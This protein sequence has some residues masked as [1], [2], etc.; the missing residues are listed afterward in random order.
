MYVQPR[1]IIIDIT[2]VSLIY[3]FVCTINCVVNILF[4]AVALDFVVVYDDAV[5]HSVHAYCRS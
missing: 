1:N 3:V 4:F 2:T 5:H